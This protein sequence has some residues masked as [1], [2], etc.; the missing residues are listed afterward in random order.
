VKSSS[1][2]LARNGSSHKRPRG[3]FET[4]EARLALAVDLGF[5][6]AFQTL[7]G[8]ATEIY[9]SSGHNDGRGGGM[10]TDGAGNRYVTVNGTFDHIVDLDP[11]PAVQAVTMDAALVKL[12]P[13]G[14]VVWKVALNATG[15]ASSPAVRILHAVDADQNVYLVGDFRGTVDFDPGPGVFNV[16]SNGGGTDYGFYMAKLN[17]A[18]QLQWLRTLAANELTPN[19]VAVDGA[20]NL[21]I[22]SNFTALTSDPPMD[23]DAG[24]GTVLVQEK[25]RYDLVVLKY[26]TDGNFVW[27]RQIGNAGASQFGNIPALGVNN[28]NDVF[29]VGFTRAHWISTPAPEPTTLRTMTP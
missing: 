4:L 5:A 24:P 11:G 18:G 1:R 12:A 13:N 16:A 22:A 3:T 26:S 27:A 23:V 9:A 17:S 20:G 28:Q 25:G 8:P 15:P 19:R 29:I 2:S 21:V 6:G 7:G 10:V 14:A